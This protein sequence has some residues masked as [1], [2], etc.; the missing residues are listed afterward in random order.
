MQRQQ[1]VPNTVTYNTSISACAKAGL[2][3]RAQQLHAQMQAAGVPDDVFTLTALI[4]GGLGWAGRAC[5]GRACNGCSGSVVG[6][7]EQAGAARPVG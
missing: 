4:T 1:V 3:A 6:D 7:K 5:A 2:Y